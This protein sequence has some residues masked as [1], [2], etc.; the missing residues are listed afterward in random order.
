M[1]SGS[2]VWVNCLPMQLIFKSYLLAKIL[3]TSS[4]NTYSGAFQIFFPASSD[5]CHLMITLANSLDP[6]QA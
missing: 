3:L 2:L 6:D 1:Q 4:K 5:F